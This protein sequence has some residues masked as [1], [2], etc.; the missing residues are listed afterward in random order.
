MSGEEPKTDISTWPEG[1]H[2][3]LAQPICRDVQ[4]ALRLTNT[5]SGESNV[6]LPSNP[7]VAD[8]H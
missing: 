7:A 6:Q 4:E 1:G 5:E 3:N 2:L 8:Q